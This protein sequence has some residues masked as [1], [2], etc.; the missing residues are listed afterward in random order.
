MRESIKLEDPHFVHNCTTWPVQTYHGDFMVMKPTIVLC[1][2]IPFIVR[3][4]KYLRPT[5]SKRI[6]M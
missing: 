6:N 1:T 2:P 5:C 4:V 3:A